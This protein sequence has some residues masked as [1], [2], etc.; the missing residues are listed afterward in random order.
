MQR[1][2]RGA[3]PGPVE[4]PQRL[5]PAPVG[6]PGRHDRSGDPEAAS[7]AATSRTGCSSRV[8]GPNRRWSRWSPSAT[9]RGSRP[10]GS[11]MLVK[12]MGIEGISK[13]QVRGWRRVS[14]VIVD[15]FRDRP[16][17]A[18]P[19]T[20]V[21]VDALTQKVREG[22]RIVNVAVCHRDRGERRGPPRDPRRRRVHHR[23]RRR[24]DRRS[25]GRS[26]PGACRAWSW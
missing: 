9:S 23:R 20:Y 12:T 17:D 21:W 26:S 16:L 2:L 3:D 19:Y 7:R 25:C 8:G 18:G 1:R 11:M 14:D 24:L 6:Y 22:G 15:A 5:P 4:S 13:S 10:G